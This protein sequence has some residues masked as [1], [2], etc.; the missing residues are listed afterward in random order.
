M[1]KNAWRVS[2]CVNLSC[3]DI[4]VPRPWVSI[5][6]IG[7]CMCLGFFVKPSWALLVPVTFMW[8][9]MGMRVDHS[10][11]VSTVWQFGPT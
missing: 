7:A 6:L 2:C 9:R 4:S 8:A 5:L 10:T 11:R 1:A 3:S